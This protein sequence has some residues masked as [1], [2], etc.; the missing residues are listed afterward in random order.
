MKKVLWSI[1]LLALI[2]AGA[3]A[4]V[5]RPVSAPTIDV[6]GAAGK[7]PA[8]S[9]TSSVY[10]IQSDESLVKFTMNELLNGKPF[11]V[12]GTTTQVAGQ[13]SV[14]ASGVT[15]GSLAVNAKTFVTDNPR[16]DNAINRAILKTEGNPANELITFDPKAGYSGAITP[17]Q[18]V[19]FDLVGDLTISG[20]TKPATFKVAM[21]VSGDQVTGTATTTIKRS[22]FGLVIPNIPFVANVDD[23]FPVTV[24]VVADR[25]ML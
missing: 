24:Q 23:E 22:D 9:A 12:V 14:S 18:P 25:I 13:V 15:F 11:L 8:G 21:T 19:S 5:T 2:G 20:V 7:L 17:G 6:E 3:Y 4:Y 10:Q 16:R 1:V